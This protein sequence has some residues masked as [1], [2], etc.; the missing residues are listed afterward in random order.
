MENK[1]VA[2]LDFWDSYNPKESLFYKLLEKHYKI[3]I[4]GKEDADYVFFSVWGNSHWFVPEHCVKIF[5][6]W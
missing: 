1:K 3:D 6:D 4:V 5:F 2:F